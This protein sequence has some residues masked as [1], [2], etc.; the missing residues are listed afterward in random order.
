[1]AVVPMVTQPE[2]VE[3]LAE[4]TGYSK[5]DVRHFLKAMND[6]VEKTIQDGH[7]IKIGHITV[8]PVLVSARKKR[9]GRNPQTG[10]EVP[11][12]AKPASTKA[13]AKVD[14]ALKEMAPSVKR[15]KNR[16]GQ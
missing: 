13:R 11:V 1:M 6:L 15:L 3:Y 12:P 8:E 4:E 14:K 9:M 5:G 7:R 10:E 16:L 2:M